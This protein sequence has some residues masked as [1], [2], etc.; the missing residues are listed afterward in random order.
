MRHFHF[1]TKKFWNYFYF[2]FKHE[3]AVVRR[4]NR[5]AWY[6]ARRWIGIC[7]QHHP[8]LLSALDS[9]HPCT[10]VQCS[11]VLALKCL[12]HPTY[13]WC[14]PVKGMALV[15]NKRSNNKYVWG[16][17]Y[18][19]RHICACLF[20]LCVC[21]LLVCHSEISAFIHYQRALLPSNIINFS[22]DIAILGHC[23]D[24][25]VFGW[26]KT[27]TRKSSNCYGWYTK[28]W[29]QKCKSF[30]PKKYFFCP[31][32]GRYPSSFAEFFPPETSL[33]I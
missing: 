20:H 24:T 19:S 11:L 27:K 4:K 32:L 5:K 29:C 12:R 1:Q 17:G 25:L 22:W 14:P 8:C 13:I 28:G 3:I 21:L 2:T 31:F 16:R 10:A 15:E 23:L 9:L 33:Q 18:A 26:V 6:F 30:S 7:P